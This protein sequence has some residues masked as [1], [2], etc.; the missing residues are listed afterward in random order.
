MA[1]DLDFIADLEWL[2][3]V[4]VAGRD[5]LV[6]AAEFIAIVDPGHR[7]PDDTRDAWSLACGRKST[8]QAFGK[9]QLVGRGGARRRLLYTLPVDSR[10]GDGSVAI[11]LEPPAQS[12]EL[13]FGGFN[14]SAC[15]VCLRLD[16]IGLFTLSP[17][18]RLRALSRACRGA[19]GGLQLA[20][21][22]S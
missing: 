8:G 13:G 1:A 17:R 6:G 10:G 20:L 11:G 15:F 3:T 7:D 22:G 5:Q 21:L 19:R 9:K 2:V 18:F 4:D 14:A 12:L 16:V